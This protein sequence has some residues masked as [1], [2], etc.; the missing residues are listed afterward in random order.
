MNIKRFF[1]ALLSFLATA[2][3]VYGAVLFI[4]APDGTPHSKTLAT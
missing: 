2:G 4:N 1:G 3:L